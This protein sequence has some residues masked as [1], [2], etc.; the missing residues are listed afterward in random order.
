MGTL[1]TAVPES[2][3]HSSLIATLGSVGPSKMSLFETRSGVGA[4]Q[5]GIW[6]PVYGGWLRSWDQPAGPD[7]AACL[8]IAEQAEAMGFD[9]LYASEIS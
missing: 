3:A 6:L 4:M 1:W 5:F 9:F 2:S 7:V 8:K